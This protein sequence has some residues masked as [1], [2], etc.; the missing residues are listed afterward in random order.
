MA[1]PMAGPL[2]LPLVLPLV[3]PL[4]PGASGSRVLPGIVVSPLPLPAIAGQGGHP[5]GNSLGSAGS[6]FGVIESYESPAEATDLGVGWTRVLFEWSRTQETGEDTWTPKVTDEQIE[7]E[8]AA[9]R[10]VVGLLIGIPGWA[11]DENLLPRG[12][13]L[14]DDDPANAWANYVRQVVSRYEG[15]INH[16]IIWNE[17]DIR[18][19]EI[20]HTWD[21][22]VADFAQLLRISYLV[23]NEANPDAVIHLSAF[24]YW[25]DYYGGT[26]QYMAR[27]L[28]ELGRDPQAV[29]NSFYFDIATAHLYF[30]PNQII[31]LL[32]LFVD[33]MRQRGLEQPIWLVETNAPPKDDPVWPVPD[34]FLS[35]T[36]EEQAAFIPQALASALSAGAERIALYKL[37]DTEDDRFANPEPFGLI[38]MDGSQRPAF[39]TFKVAIELMAGT[40]A[41]E[42]ERW[43]E[44]GQ[45]RLE[46]AGMTTTVLFSRLPGQ[47][48]SQVRATT[49]RASLVDM[50]GVSR[51]IDPVEGFYTVELTG[52]QCSQSIGDYCMIRGPTYY[53]V[54]SVRSPSTPTASPSPSPSVTAQETATDMAPELPAPTVMATHSPTAMFS[55][56]PTMDPT[57]TF[58]PLLSPSA[59]ANITPLPER[60]EQSAESSIALGLWF[61]GGGI[62]LAL[63]I[64]V[65]WYVQHRR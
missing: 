26:E 25:A 22:T 65:D 58:A 37:K 34:W 18:E 32:G 47:Q 51:A 62:L 42:R 30:Q 49:D 44:V 27:L 9:G 14:P 53:R 52:A 8:L 21:G 13:W 10:E 38:R 55:Q 54:Q 35:V 28:D 46:Q 11:R 5:R 20:A 23:A 40:T 24:T 43:D 36:L 29:E 16:W 48:V 60:S 61:I 45:I 59:K 17:P 15:R 63:V 64:F 6:L 2:A 19:T 33:I 41:A 39:D 57:S 56:S 4:G 7:A 50:W 3:L 12:L 1:G 31:D